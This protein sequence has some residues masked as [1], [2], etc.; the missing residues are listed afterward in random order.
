ML[1]L[2]ML[3]VSGC[4][5][6]AKE[7]PELSRRSSYEKLFAQ[8]DRA[9]AEK[10][11]VERCMSTPSPPHLPWPDNLVRLLCADEWAPV[12]QASDVKAMIDRRDWAGLHDRYSEY[13]KRHLSGEDPERLL[14]RA[15]PV[16]NWSSADEAD[17]YTRKWVSAK[18][19]DPFSNAARGIVLVRAAWRARGTGYARDVTEKG[20][21]DMHEN[22]RLAV[23][24]LRHAIDIEPRLMPA[25][26]ALI[27]AYMLGGKSEWMARVADAASQQSPDN[28]YVRSN[29]ESFLQPKWG[30]SLQEIDALAE[31]SR[32][33]IHRNPRLAMVGASS[34]T[35][36]GDAAFHKGKFST[37]LARYRKALAAGPTYPPLADA[38]PA[39][40]KL[41]YHA[42]RIMYLTQIIRFS[43]ESIDELLDRGGMWEWD[44]DYPRALR[45]YRRASEMAP[46]DP[47]IR[48]K[49][50]EVEKK[51]RARKS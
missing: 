43:R 29:Y 31:Q 24:H 2:L 27:D 5:E 17:R 40:S 25:Y 1:G 18:P 12:M 22:A 20:R 41:G 36:I 23:Q 47:K 38:G 28:F 35:T 51:M 26:E 44:R 16:N 14:Y 45:D 30:G 21:K 3:L 9:E 48:E 10:D 50:A 15:F 7:I 11:P 6:Q 42:E 13:L 33:G 39:A 37:A 34:D 19:D 4:Q 8:I 46:A 32:P 49:I